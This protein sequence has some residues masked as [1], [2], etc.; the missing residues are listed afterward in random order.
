MRRIVV[1]SLC[2]LL[3]ATVSGAAA[4]PIGLSVEVLKDP[5]LIACPYCHKAI[6]PG[7]IGEDAEDILSTEMGGSLDEKG[8]DHTG[9]KNAARGLDVFIYRF[10]E[11]MG[12]SIGAEKPASVG[13]HVHLRERGKV[14]NVFVFDETQRPLS[15]NVLALPVFVKRGAKWITAAE[16]AR[17]GVHKAIGLFA[18]DLIESK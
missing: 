2:L 15:E 10:Q 14:A 1:L 17:E 9:G 3:A 13:F 8:F 11:R 18:N 5:N 16:L 6:A 4:A 7:E 12:G